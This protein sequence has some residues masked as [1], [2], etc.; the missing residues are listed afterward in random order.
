MWGSAVARRWR[1]IVLLANWSY[2]LGLHLWNQ[3]WK[4]S[5]LG[6]GQA[7]FGSDMFRSIFIYTY[8]NWRSTNLQVQLSLEYRAIEAVKL[9]NPAVLAKLPSL[10]L[11][12][13]FLNGKRKLLRQVALGK[14]LT[15]A[16]IYL[17]FEFRKMTVK[18]LLSFFFF[19]VCLGLRSFFHCRQKRRVVFWCN[20]QILHCT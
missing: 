4:R 7:L 17:K 12:L 18:N 20:A 19:L 13:F 1:K 9:P 15:C 3:T 2:L 5:D 10:S 14:L 16:Q 6:E 8:E 11:S